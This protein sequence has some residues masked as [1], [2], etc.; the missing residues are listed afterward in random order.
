MKLFALVDTS[1]NTIEVGPRDWNVK[2]W[3]RFLVKQNIEFKDYPSEIPT[4][5]FDIPG[6]NYVILPVNLGAI[7]TMDTFYQQPAGPFYTINANN[8]DAVYQ[9]GNKSLD[10]IAYKIKQD[11]TDAR[12]KKEIA[13]VDV[14]GMSIPTDR[15]SQSLITGTRLKSDNDNSRSFNWK[16]SNGWITL[17]RTAVVALS[18]AVF[19]YVEG[20]FDIEHNLHNAVDD[21]IT[22]NS[23]DFSATVTALRAIDIEA[24]FA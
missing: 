5:K 11:A 7:P 4:V 21:A 6:T 24:A 19:D 16:G 2:F 23:G 22:N 18:D 9:I 3:N 17:D 20:C 1:T 15:Q 10:A 13:G 8:I 12:F 14:N